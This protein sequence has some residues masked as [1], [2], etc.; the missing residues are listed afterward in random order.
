MLVQ[1]VCWGWGL[2]QPRKPNWRR[3]DAVDVELGQQ[4]D[5]EEG[6]PPGMG[7]MGRLR[8]WAAR[9]TRADSAGGLRQLI[10]TWL[11][12]R[13]VALTALVSY[14][15]VLHLLLAVCYLYHH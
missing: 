13:P 5:P 2:Q 3:L 10:A 8:T 6:T 7:P 4:D 12:T 1:K 11:R 14:F 15:I 9:V